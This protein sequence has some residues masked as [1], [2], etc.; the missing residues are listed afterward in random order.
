MREKTLEDKRKEMAII[1]AKLNEENDR[2]KALFD[3]Q[4]QVKKNIDYFYEEGRE[5]NIFEITG[6]KDFLA[7]IMTDIQN[8][9]LLVER[10][11]HVLH[12]KQ[13][14]VTE[15]LKE[16]KVLEKLKEKQ[17]TAF[18]KSVSLMEAKELDDIATTRYAKASA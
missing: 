12:L 17:E 3:R 14:E 8:Q 10:I 13:R 6:H 4:T 11:K 9:D 15:A 18:Y 2:L 16:V 1:I 5:I 7:K